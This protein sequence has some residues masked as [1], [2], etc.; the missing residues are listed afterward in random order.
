AV[1]W[2]PSGGPRRWLRGRSPG[3]RGLR[4]APSAGPGIPPPPPPL[5]SRA[6]PAASHQPHAAATVPAHTAD[7]RLQPGGGNGFT[8]I[9]SAPIASAVQQ[10]D[11]LGTGVVTSGGRRAIPPFD[12]MKRRS[13][14]F[15]GY[16]VPVRR[17]D[18]THLGLFEH[19]R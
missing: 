17:Q 1:G 4:A 14:P 3:R 8:T 12:L 18:R 6:P 11:H 19:L 9:V 7:P 10:P 2:G 5:T 13:R 15:D 16:P